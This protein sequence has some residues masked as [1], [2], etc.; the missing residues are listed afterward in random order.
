LIYVGLGL[1]ADY[2]AAIN[3]LE[4]GHAFR[5]CGGRSGNNAPCKTVTSG[6]SDISMPLA[7]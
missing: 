4:A 2:N 5:D 6:N 3:I 1:N 7:A